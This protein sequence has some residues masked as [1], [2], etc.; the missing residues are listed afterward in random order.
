MLA[1]PQYDKIKLMKKLKKILQLSDP[2]PNL[3]YEVSCYLKTILG[4][5][6]VILG[7]FFVFSPLL[8]KGLVIFGFAVILNRLGE[9]VLTWEVK[10]FEQ[11]FY[12]LSLLVGLLL[13]IVGF[14][15]FWQIKLVRKL[16]RSFIN[17]L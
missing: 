13:I 2:Y 8:K 14:G 7:F 6:F 9:A 15:I 11:N 10:T 12:A 17:F 1:Y 4:L 3:W 16:I 5:I